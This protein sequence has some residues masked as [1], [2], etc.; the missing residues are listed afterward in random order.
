MNFKVIAG[1]LTF[2]VLMVTVARLSILTTVPHATNVHIQRE[3]NSSL[4]G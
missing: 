3:Y 2:V 4:L 1:I